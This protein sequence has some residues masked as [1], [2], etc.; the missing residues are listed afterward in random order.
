MY[1]AG[2]WSLSSFAKLV[3]LTGSGGSPEGEERGRVRQLFPTSVETQ[4]VQSSAWRSGGPTISPTAKL[5]SAELTLLLGARRE[6]Y[7]PLITQIAKRHL[8][9]MYLHRLT[10]APIATKSL[11][12]NLTAVCGFAYRSAARSRCPAAGLVVWSKGHLTDSMAAIASD[13]SMRITLPETTA[14]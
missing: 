14:F 13:T 2:A 6:L 9:S 5:K 10:N 4:T 11:K 12:P 1:R 7:S 8:L 3:L